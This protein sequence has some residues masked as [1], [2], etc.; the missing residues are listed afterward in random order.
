MLNSD[1]VFGTIWSG[2]KTEE[3]DGE[4]KD[5]D[6]VVDDL[7]ED[8]EDKEDKEEEDDEEDEEEEVPIS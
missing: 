5:E 4:K 6:K 1:Y 7:D 3:E 2:L 8:E